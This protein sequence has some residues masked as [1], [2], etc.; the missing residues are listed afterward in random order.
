MRSVIVIAACAAALSGCA[1]LGALV[2]CTALA[3]MANTRSSSVSGAVN[4]QAIHSDVTWAARRG[5]P[6]FIGIDECY[7]TAKRERQNKEV[8]HD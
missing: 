6:G 4:G 3:T 1:D 8:P 7:A 2:G 5:D